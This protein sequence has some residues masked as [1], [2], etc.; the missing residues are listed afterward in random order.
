MWY[1]D[2]SCTWKLLKYSLISIMKNKLG[3]VYLI[4]Y[5]LG[6]FFAVCWKMLMIFRFYIEYPLFLEIIATTCNLITISFS[7]EH[8]K[9]SQDS[10]SPF[11][12]NMQT[13]YLSSFMCINY[14]TEIL[15]YLQ[16]VRTEMDL[17]KQIAETVIRLGKKDHF[18]CCNWLVIRRGELLRDRSRQV[19]TIV[20]S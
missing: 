20:S 4:R 11:E 2:R 12:F 19:K 17:A 8:G 9:M 18:G 6:A 10:K 3:H 13:V 5:M 15:W 16:W 1:E 7:A 14:D